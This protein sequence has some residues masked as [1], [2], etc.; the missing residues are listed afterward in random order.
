MKAFKIFNR[1]MFG[2]D[3]EEEYACNLNRAY[4]IFNNKVRNTIDEL[5]GNIID[6]NDFSE[7]VSTLKDSFLF[8]Q[9]NFEIISRKYPYILYK[10]KDKDIYIADI[11][12]WYKT[13]HEYD[14]YDIETLSVVMKEIDI[15]E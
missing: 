12:G 11:Y 6:K 8:K 1:N 14:E 4:K 7:Q 9:G 15:Q 10:N 5:A 3:T 13:N 2:S